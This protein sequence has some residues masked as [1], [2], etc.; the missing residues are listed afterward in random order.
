MNPRHPKWTSGIHRS[1]TADAH[2]QHNKMPGQ[3]NAHTDAQLEF[4][5]TVIKIHARRTA[6]S[7]H[8]DKVC[9]IVKFALYTT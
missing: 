6:L 2:A 8:D 9:F 5:K 7:K 1:P 3:R 4:T